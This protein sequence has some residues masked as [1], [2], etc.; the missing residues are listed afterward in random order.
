MVSKVYNVGVKSVVGR[1]VDL[2][3]CM[4]KK[5]GECRE[6]YMMWN[7]TYEGLVMDLVMGRSVMHVWNMRECLEAL[8]LVQSQR[9]ILNLDAHH[10]VMTSLHLV[11]ARELV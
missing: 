1:S 6:I 7:V 3:S 4:I 2:W 10:V 8:A 11:R 9:T 5:E